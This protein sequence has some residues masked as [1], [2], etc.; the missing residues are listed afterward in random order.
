MTRVK[1][2]KVEDAAKQIGKS[3]DTIRRWRR[4]GRLTFISGHVDIDRVVE[5][6]KMMRERN[7]TEY[8]SPVVALARDLGVDPDDLRTG[9][10][11]MLKGMH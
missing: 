3:V 2:V 8:G 10:A 7:P 9:I 6:E 4:E 1:W 5:I 11:A